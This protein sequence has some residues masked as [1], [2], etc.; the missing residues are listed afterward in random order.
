MEK[1]DRQAVMVTEEE[2][3]EMLSDCP[4]LYH[5]AE[6]GS[7][8]SVRE[9][10]LLSTTALLDLYAVRE[11]ER[12]RIEG[13]RRARGVPLNHSI[14][15]RAVIRDQIPMDDAGLRRCL[16]AH[17]EPSDWYRMLNTKVF[18]W[19]TRHRLLV[20]LGAG[21]YRGQSHD[22]I[23]VRSRPLVEAYYKKIWLC[24]MNSGCT[25]PFPHARNE[26]TFRRIPDY[27]YSERRKKKKP[28]ERVV[29]LAVDYAVPNIVEFM[30]RVVE[31]R[32]TEEIRTIDQT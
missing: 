25:K 8:P 19:L 23:E 28:G 27:P 26:E 30:V 24:P 13:E 2:L 7:W 1:R 16:P 5:M 18:F 32:G 4:M 11:P 9:R 10:G 22:V 31:M 15:P 6:H 17:L 21:A 3:N 12:A 20:L 29:E 14:L